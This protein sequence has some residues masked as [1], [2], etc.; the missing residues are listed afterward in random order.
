MSDETTEPAEDD[1]LVF[2]LDDPD[3]PQA[4]GSAIIKLPRRMRQP[5]HTSASPEH[6]IGTTVAGRYQV[7]RELARGGMGVVYLARQ[8]KL[9]RDVV[10]KVLSQDLVDSE[11]A[12]KRFD[13]EARGMSQLHHPNLVTIFDYGTEEGIS[14]IVMEYVDG[15]P[16]SNL[17]RRRER[18]FWSDF[19]RVAVQILDAVAE[20][21]EAGVIHRDLKPDNVLLCARHGQEDF[22]KILDFGLARFRGNKEVTKELYG[23]VGY[24]APEIVRG[25]EI[26]QRT[27]VY[28]LGAMFY[29]MLTGTKPFD[30]EHYA[31]MHQHVTEEPQWMEERMPFDHL[32]P[33]GALRLIHRALSKD[34][35]DRPR[36]AGEFLQLLSAEVSRWTG[37]MP[38]DVFEGS[39]PPRFRKVLENAATASGQYRTVVPS[40]GVTAETR[41]DSESGSHVAPSVEAAEPPPAEQA[42]APT[43]ASISPETASLSRDRADDGPRGINPWV[44]YAMVAAGIGLVV[45]A[46]WPQAPQPEGDDVAKVLPANLSTRDVTSG[47]QTVEKLME[48]KKFGRATALLDTLQPSIDRPRLAN[49]AAVLRDRIETEQLLVAAQMAHQGGDVEEARSLFRQILMRDPNHVAAT[50]GFDSLAAIDDERRAS[51][52]TAKLAKREVA[53]PV[54]PAEGVQENSEDDEA[55]PEFTPLTDIAEDPPAPPEERPATGDAVSSPEPRQPAMKRAKKKQKQK[56]RDTAE[57]SDPKPRVFVVPEEPGE[58][59]A[60]P[61]RE[62]TEPDRADVDPDREVTEEDLLRAIGAPDEKGLGGPAES[63]PP[64]AGAQ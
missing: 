49:E 20:A 43:G 62:A 6:L 8:E 35:D 13:R 4:P 38:Y 5:S 24:I 2:D 57:S 34:P 36:D 48:Q 44:I 29:E 9:D 18:F 50:E 15:D 40:E 60:P 1:P 52:P 12:R 54:E 41:R 47:L 61:E 16:L 11:Q 59:D 17:L 55:T 63:N 31:V 42:P 21:H 14:Y 64:D 19:V 22:V 39:V 56:E 58:F 26:D 45:Y 25:E 30:G 33:E 53:E 46:L 10:L 27:D 28:A 32:C 23:S 51:P 3:V 37:L 7:E